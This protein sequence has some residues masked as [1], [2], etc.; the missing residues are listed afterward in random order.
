MPQKDV[1][2]WTS[3]LLAY[4]RSGH[5]LNAQKTFDEMPQHSLL[6]WNASCQS[7]HT[8]GIYN[9]PKGLSPGCPSMISCRGI[10]F[11]RPERGGDLH[12]AKLLFDVMPQHDLVAWTAMLSAYALNEDVDSAQRIFRE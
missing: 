10:P 4:A 12:G 7:T 3:M 5:I 8:A 6:S 9:M 1:L 2:A 11:L